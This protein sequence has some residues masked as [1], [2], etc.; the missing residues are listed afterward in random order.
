L[1][2]WPVIAGATFTVSTALELLTQPQL[3]LTTT[4]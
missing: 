3:L 4:E 1:V 2:G